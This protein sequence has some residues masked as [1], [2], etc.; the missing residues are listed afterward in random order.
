MSK[1][2]PITTT[3]TASS[4]DVVVVGGAIIGSSVAWWLSREPGFDGTVLVVEKDP[5]YQQC[6]T[7]HTN[8]CMRQQ[9]SNPLNVQISRFAADYVRD[10]RSWMDDDPGGSRDLRQPLRLHVP[11]RR[12][13]VR[14]HAAHQPAGASRARCRHE[15]H[16]ARG[17]QGRLS[18]LQRRRHRLR[19]P[20]PDRRGVLRQR[21]DVRLVAEQGPRERCRVSH[22]R[23]RRR[24]KGRR[25]GDQRVPGV[26]RDSR[27][28]NSSSTPPVRVQCGS[29]TWPVSNCPSSPASGTPTSSI[30]PRTSAW[31]SRSRSTPPECTCVPRATR[32]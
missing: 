27:V 18:L 13:H 2:T 30:A 32:T 15:D 1:R 21:H 7:A 24:G 3:P 28:W 9:F 6:S 12:R 16:D 8:S 11:G 25:P 19:Q 17:D 4:Y 29:P 22:R 5:L 31:M 26:G 14:R 10:F 23:G 20:Q